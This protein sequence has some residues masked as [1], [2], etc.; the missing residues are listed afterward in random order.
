MDQCPDIQWGCWLVFH[1]NTQFLMLYLERGCV[2]SKI[3]VLTNLDPFSPLEMTFF[4]TG[5]NVSESLQYRW[6]KTVFHCQILLLHLHPPAPEQV[7]IF[8][9]ET[10]YIY[11]L[12]FCR[13]VSANGRNVIWGLGLQRVWQI[14]TNRKI[15]QLVSIC[16][17]VKRKDQSA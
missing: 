15:R 7:I 16:K 3:V 13:H 14:R 12:G 6:L 5:K 1:T 17:Q 10:H 9:S 11:F 8:S 2:C 4:W